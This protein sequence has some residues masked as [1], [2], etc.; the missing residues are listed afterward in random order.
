MKKEKIVRFICDVLIV[1]FL[2]GFVFALY[3]Y[4]R[5]S[6]EMIP[7]EEQQEKALIGAILLMIVT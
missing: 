7:S 2:L 6:F 3:W 1:F 4:L 5:G